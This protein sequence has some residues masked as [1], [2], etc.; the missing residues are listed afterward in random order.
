MN[1]SEL[2]SRVRE[3][4]ASVHTATSAEQ[5]ISHG[6]AVRARRRI[7]GAAGTLTVAAGVTLAVAALLPSSHQPAAHM[8]AWTVAKQ[9]NGDVHVTI[10]ELR[11]PAGLQSRL[12]A[13]GVPASV[14]I[15]ANPSCQPYQLSGTPTPEQRR[16]VLGGVFHSASRSTFVIHPAA[17][18]SG[19]GIAITDKLPTSEGGF[20]VSLVQASQQCTGT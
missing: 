16:G 15:A 20:T 1:D 5:I 8:A 9:A 12:R 10:R 2:I 7:S 14:S 11:D 13:D 6:R 4:V 18:P 19:S 17:L 3:S